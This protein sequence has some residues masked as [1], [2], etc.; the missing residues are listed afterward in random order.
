M[1]TIIAKSIVNQ[2]KLEEFMALTKEM[3]KESR[4]EDGCLSYDL[5][6]DVHND[7]I[8]T[9]IEEWENMEAI[10]RHNESEHFNRILPQMKALRSLSSEV[11]LYHPVP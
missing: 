1:I 2:G 4:K 3:I 10:Q 8:L 7:H 6:Q 11:N 9:L 5:Y